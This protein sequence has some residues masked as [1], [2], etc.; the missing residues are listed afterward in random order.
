MATNTLPVTAA[1]RQPRAII[2]V[3]GQTVTG[4]ISWTVRNNTYFEADTFEVD[5]AVSALPS[6]NDANWF[7]TQ[8]ET[9]VEIFAGFPQ[10]PADPQ[11]PELTSLIYGRVDDV[12]YDPVATTLR[13]TGRDLTAVFIDK[14]VAGTLTSDGV[15]TQ[16]RSSDIASALASAHGIATDITATTQIVG[17]FDGAQNTIL[18]ANRSEWDLLCWLARE[19]GFVCYIAGQTLYFGPDPI[20][21][22]SAYAILWEAPGTQQTASGAPSANVVSIQCSRSMTIAKG[23]SVT[24]YSAQ[25]GTGKAITQSYPVTPKSIA[26]GSSSPFG[27]VLNYYYKMQPNQTAQ[28]VSAYAERRYNEHAAHEMKIRATLPGDTILN[29]KTLVSLSGTN[30]AFDQVYYPRVVTREMSMDAGFTM[31]LEAQNSAQETS[32][33]QD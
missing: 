32:V 3:N 2:Q 13:L 4:W 11:I 25:Q 7:S 33:T 14:R 17:T 12:T 26:P 1:A 15:Y 18:R 31:S 27:P 6:S 8:T 22:S 21:S 9:F 20:S 16:K 23:I 30:T 5:F 19:E 24:A 28:Q 10:N 29:T